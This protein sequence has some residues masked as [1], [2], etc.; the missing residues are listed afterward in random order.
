MRSV[1]CGQLN[2]SHI[3]KTVTLY[4]WV[5]K[6]RNLGNIIFIDMRDREGI[7]QVLFNSN[8]K[9][10]FQIASE[11]RNEFCIKVTGTVYERNLKNKNTKIVTGEVEV[12]AEDIYII[13]KSE[14][15]P[16]DFKHQ[17][18]E[19]T[20]LKYRYLDLR[21]PEMIEKIKI[22][23]KIVN[24][25]H[26]FMDNEG[27]INIETPTLTKA[28][29]EGARDYL[30]PSRKYKGKF[31]ALP[32]SPQLFKQILMISGF[33]R[34]YQIVKCFRDEDI[35]SDRQPEFTQIDIETSFLNSNEIRKIM[36]CLIRYLWKKIKN[37]DLGVFPQIS[38]NEAISKYGSDKPDL[39]NPMEIIDVSDIFK[40]DVYSEVFSILE[41]TKNN[42]IAV[43][44]V[45]NGSII[46]NKKI[47]EYTKFMETYEIKNL[48]WIKVHSQEKA[49][50]GILNK[51]IMD[52]DFKIVQE[53]IYRTKSQKGD[54]IFLSGGDSNNI[55]NALG[56]LRLKIGNDLKITN[57][58]TWKP[59]WII[60]FPMFKNDQKGKLVAMHHPFTAPKGMD[61]S[62]LLVNPIDTIADS[63]DMVINGCEVG[64]G[65]VRIH[66]N[67]IQKTVFN[68]LGINEH[69][70]NEKF[71]FLLNA[72]K[73]GA[74]QHAGLA[75]GLDR[76]TMLLTE[77]NNIRD[78]IAFPKSTLARCL[79]TQSPSKIDSSTLY[80]LGIKLFNNK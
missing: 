49:V 37:I 60:D 16:I 1:Y 25:I 76:L 54:I 35:R 34:Y 41:N 75:F 11:L 38:F 62:T 8:Y 52:F 31:Y 15:I 55:S 28:T 50:T 79:M 6:Y 23:S 44:R 57:N 29:P 59:L 70:Q 24:L 10:T 36:E 51:I 56:V 33:D 71:G 20:R 80:E 73:F 78:V 30:V 66:N 13:N 39:R 12:L 5:N 67:E 53:I 42:R 48:I 61:I 63:Y 58:K 77:T 3:G 27:F 74:P 2:I 19:D 40:N 14:V 7:V 17:N 72:L 45:P 18:T 64:G 65:S 21:R 46:S 22:R 26:Q 9:N 32:Q 69:E 4:G 47:V 43:L 68:L